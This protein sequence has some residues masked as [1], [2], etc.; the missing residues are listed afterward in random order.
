MVPEDPGE[1]LTENKVARTYLRRADFERW[2]L[3]ESCSGHLRTGQGRQQSHSEGATRLAAADERINRTLADSVERHTT[4]GRGVRGVLKR[5]SVV[6]HP[7]TESQKKIAM[8]TEQDPTP[9]PSVSC[10]GSSASGARPSITTSADLNTDLTTE[11]RSGFAQ[12]VTRTSSEDHIGDDV[13]MRGYD[14]DEYSGCHPSSAASDRRRR[15]TMKR[16]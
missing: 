2:V 11:V 10:R 16:E 1:V 13:A 7:E 4:K 8:D 14:G 12:D 9:H 6:C 15:Y 3:S 5:P